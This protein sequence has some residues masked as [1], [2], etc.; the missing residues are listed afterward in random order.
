MIDYQNIQLTENNL[1]NSVDT[2]FL[3]FFLPFFMYYYSAF[4]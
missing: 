4:F 1:I 3:I 2:G